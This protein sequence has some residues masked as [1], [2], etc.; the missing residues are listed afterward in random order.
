MVEFGPERI[1]A[2]VRYSNHYAKTNYVAYLTKAIKENYAAGWEETAK[3]AIERLKAAEACEQDESE[4]RA[5]EEQE[6]AAA[7][8]RYESLPEPEKDLLREETLRASP[9]LASLGEKTIRRMML[10]R[11]CDSGKLLSE[12]HKSRDGPA[13]SEDHDPA[14]LVEMGAGSHNPGRSTVSRVVA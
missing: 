3:S 7:E 4:Q 11:L 9:F 2:N 12:E 10:F 5:R 14:A 8:V 6:Y 13:D 1:A